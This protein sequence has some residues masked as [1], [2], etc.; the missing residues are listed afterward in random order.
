MWVLMLVFSLA[1]GSVVGAVIL[2]VAIAIYNSLAGAGGKKKRNRV[3]EL[4]FGQ[5]VTISFLSMLMNVVLGIISGMILGLIISSEHSEFVSNVVMYLPRILTWPL[6]MLLVTLL[7]MKTMPTS[8][9]KALLVSL[10]ATG[11]GMLLTGLFGV[12]AMVLGMVLR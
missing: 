7:L 8:F 9:P 12:I 10:I 5:A 6:S 4:E 2:Q 1:I 3:P 11:I